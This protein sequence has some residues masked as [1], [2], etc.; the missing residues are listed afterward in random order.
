MIT[1]SEEAKRR[2]GIFTSHIKQRSTWRRSELPK[3][4]AWGSKERRKSNGDPTDKERRILWKAWR[5]DCFLEKWS[6]QAIQ[7]SK[8]FSSSGWHS[9]PSNITIG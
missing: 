4:S 9:Q 1:Q 7:E 3:C 2:E 5:R 8:G 6:R